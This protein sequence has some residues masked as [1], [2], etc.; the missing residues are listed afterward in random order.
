ML[1]QVPAGL[2]EDHLIGALQTLLDHHDALRLRLIAPSQSTDFSLEIAP[3]GTVDA[4]SCLR[5]IDIRGLTADELRAAITEQAQAAEMRLS[6]VVG[7]MMQ[8]VWFD[9]GAAAAGRLLLSIHH[10]AVDGVSWRILVP[11]LAA[12][13]AAIARGKEASLA[14]RGTSFRR[15]AHRLAAE[16][17]EAGRVGE[18]SFWTGMLS[19]PVTFCCR[20]LA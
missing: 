15:W 19:E 7:V 2:R 13:W 9:A 17:E 11:D 14:P 10:L 18:L 4:K 6:P 20:W 16:A 8:A 1:L 12:A 3:S 5:R